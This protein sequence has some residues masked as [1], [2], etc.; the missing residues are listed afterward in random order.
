MYRTGVLWIESR[1]SDSDAR[2]NVLRDRIPHVDRLSG[3]SAILCV[4]D[5]PA[6]W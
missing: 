2:A 1:G 3:L 6:D 4:D 5:L